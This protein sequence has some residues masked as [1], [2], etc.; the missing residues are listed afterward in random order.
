ML[1]VAEASARI[2]A[3]V[4]PLTPERVPL[5][6]A[7]GRVL[8]EDITAPLTLP[9]WDNSAM[10]GYAVRGDDVAAASEAAPVILT[11]LETVAAGAFPSRPIGPGEATRIMTGAPIPGGAD[12]VVRVEDTDGGTSQVVVRNARDLRKN[13]R[14]RG[15]DLREGEVV[16]RAGTPIAA[17]QV[18]VL[19][20]VGAAQVEVR[21]RPR[22]AILGSGDELVDLDRFH[23]VLAG[24][25]IVSSNSYTLHAL[26]RSAGA[27]PVNLGVAADTPAS[28]RERLERAAGCD[29]I[30]TSAGIS[31]GEFDYTR[32]VLESLGAEMA[33]WRVRMRPGAPLGFGMLRGTP[34]VGLPGNP[35]S[36][37]VTFELF[38]RPLLRR[39]A[40]Y[41]RLF[42]R[43]TPVRLEEPVTLGA[44]LTHFFRGVVTAQPDGSLTARLTGPQGSGILTSM[45]LANALLVVPES[46]P[47]CEA[48][49][50]VNALLITDDAQLATTF[51]L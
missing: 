14:P 5:L 18:G 20:S 24:R 1:S 4:G 33:F 15:E 50:V 42:R 6:D 13:V 28:L 41:E 31:V 34:W 32:E 25:K 9:A 17:A 39:M 29:L 48:G 43:P 10:D 16:L 30:L 27:D 12:T 2:L 38:V 7:L 40:G 21:R 23:E 45:A 22:V 19:A 37:M 51:A 3:D 46:R 47:R 11:V 35:V 8:A 26:V 44:R 36:T 49:E